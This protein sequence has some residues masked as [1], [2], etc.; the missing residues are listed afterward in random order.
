MHLVLQAGTFGFTRLVSCLHAHFT[1]WFLHA[2]FRAW[3]GLNLAFGFVL[4]IVE[5]LISCLS[6]LGCPGLVAALNAP[7][8]L[9][10]L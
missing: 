10:S 3:F 1:F 5:R 6:R 9:S 4:V 2:C 7:V 8:G